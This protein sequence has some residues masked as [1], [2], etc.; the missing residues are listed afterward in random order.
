MNTRGSERERERETD[1]TVKGTAPRW[2]LEQVMSLLMIQRVR[3]EETQ[4]ERE[5]E[6]EGEMAF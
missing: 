6:R 4:G 5:N 2:S 1:K 3:K